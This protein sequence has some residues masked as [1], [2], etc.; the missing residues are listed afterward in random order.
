M[1]IYATAYHHNLLKDVERLAGFYDAIRKKAW[2]IVY[3]IGAGT[4]ILSIFAAPFVDF[5]Y[6]VEIDPLAAEYAKQNL[7]SFDNVLV[8]NKDAREVL[9]PKKA[10]LIICEMLD[11]ALIDEEQVPIVN[12]ILKYLKKDGDIVPRKILTGAEPVFVA[13][14][15]IC[16]EEG[17]Y[18]HHEIL[19]NL[20]IYNEVDLRG[21]IKEEVNV[22]LEF[23]VH[24][25]GIMSG[26]KLTSFTLLTP[27][28]ICGPTPM[29]NPPLFIPTNKIKVKRED[30]IKLNLSYK[31]GG[32]LDSIRAEVEEI[33]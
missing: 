5:V 32:G 16:Y 11:T 20:V 28:M 25:K 7:R 9:F 29:L 10:D 17:G 33:S 13:A 24:K 4:G 19:G 2:G 31:M 6:V 8:I 21:K 15:H 12:S 26:I 1:E 18:P 3:D 14:E 23:R 27:D 22:K 30:H